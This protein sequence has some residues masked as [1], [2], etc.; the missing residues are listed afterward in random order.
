MTKMQTPVCIWKGACNKN[1][2]FWHSSEL[3]SGVILN[4]FDL[5]YIIKY[6]HDHLIIVMAESSWAK[7]A[8]VGIIAIIGIVAALVLTGKIEIEASS[9]SSTG[10]SQGG[11]AF[12]GIGGLILIPIVIIVIL[13]GF[14]LLGGVLKKRA[15]PLPQQRQ[16]WQ[17]HI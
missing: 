10:P 1:F 17:W 3:K 15:E 9:A 5:S 4:V 12:G 13:I 11:S 16:R 6:H 8:V 14:K 2:F 7:Y